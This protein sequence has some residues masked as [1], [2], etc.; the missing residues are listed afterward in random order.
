MCLPL[1]C[2]FICMTTYMVSVAFNNYH[3]VN[4]LPYAR[5]VY[6]CS[7]VMHLVP[8]SQEI[9]L[10]RNFATGTIFSGKFG[11]Y[12]RG[13]AVAIF[14]R[15][16]DCYTCTKT[17]SQLTKPRTLKLKL[18]LGADSLWLAISNCMVSC[19]EHQNFQIVVKFPRK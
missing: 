1:V 19:Q 16:F 17:Y 14:L 11:H 18:N 13:D 15:K 3:F 10:L 12:V 5:T 2:I 6:M 8:L 7:R 4:F 9:W